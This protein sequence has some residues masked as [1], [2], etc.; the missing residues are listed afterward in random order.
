MFTPRLQIGYHA[1]SANL[2]T[3]PIYVLV[4]IVTCGV[5]FYADRKGQRGRL[6]MHVLFLFLT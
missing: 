2:L 1:T 6:N 3:V 5:G 4:S